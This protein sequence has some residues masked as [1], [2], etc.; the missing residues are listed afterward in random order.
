VRTVILRFGKPGGTP[1]EG[2]QEDQ[3]FYFPGWNLL[4]FS[5]LLYSFLDSHR[6]IVLKGG[7]KSSLFSSSISVG[8]R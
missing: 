7:H 8:S 6:G 4:C 2:K 5:L 3:L 1:D